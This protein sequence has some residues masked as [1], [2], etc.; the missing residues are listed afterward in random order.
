[1]KSQKQTGR[2][3]FALSTAKNP[4]RNGGGV[5]TTDIQEVVRRVVH[6]G[7]LVRATTDGKLGKKRH[8]SVGLGKLAI[9]SYWL[10][11][12][13]RHLANGALIQPDAHLPG[14]AGE[15]D[16]TCTPTS[17]GTIGSR[18]PTVVVSRSRDASKVAED[19]CDNIDGN[20]TR[21]AFGQLEAVSEI[22]SDPLCISLTAT[23]RQSLVNARV[24]QGT[25][26]QRL[27]ELWGYQCAVTNCSVLCAL[28]ASHAKPWSQST[29]AERLDP[30][31]G[32]LLAA[33]VD[34]LFDRGLISFAD[35]GRLL[36]NSLS[37]D[38]LASVGLTMHS[39][40]RFT[41][42]QHIPYLAAH[43]RAHGYET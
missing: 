19:G 35:D 16:L 5:Y 18:V 24:G 3:G 13:L 10:S 23:E 27:L 33:S 1:M 40:L 12:E 14:L 37:H 22:D 15:S 38:D 6:D 28:I 43:R 31:N 34:R 20:D 41:N 30:H 9:S 26:R 2:Y 7:W 29:N 36:T 25:Y 32:L 39:T 8:G 42:R 17:A 21:S 11:P 4:D